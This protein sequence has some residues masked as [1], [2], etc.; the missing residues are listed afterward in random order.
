MMLNGWVIADYL[1]ASQIILAVFEIVVTT[2]VAV[3]VVRS[4]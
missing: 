4:V 1:Q 3:W 2:F